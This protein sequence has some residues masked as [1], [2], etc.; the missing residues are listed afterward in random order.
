M[1]EPT[2]EDF[3]RMKEA[4]DAAEVRPNYAIVWDPEMAEF[5]MYSLGDVC[6]QGIPK[7]EP[8]TQANERTGKLRQS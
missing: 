4:L 3:R 5:V 1:M 8:L 7:K 2:L 6:E